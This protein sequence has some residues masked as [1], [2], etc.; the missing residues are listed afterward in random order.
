MAEQR[1]GGGDGI[2][3]PASASRM[4]KPNG[5]PTVRSN[6]AAGPT[7]VSPMMSP[8][9]TQV[10]DL[11]Q[12]RTGGVGDI[13]DEP[14]PVAES[15]ASPRWLCRCGIVGMIAAVALLSRSETEQSAGGSGWFGAVR[16]PIIV[17]KGA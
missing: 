5:A 7:R 3:M 13:A 9:V 2:P 11:Q 12:T 8:T 14:V 6:S 15:A 17:R 16:R 4:G 10:D 1:V